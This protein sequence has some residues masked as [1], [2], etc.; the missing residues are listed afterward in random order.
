MPD[1]F[2]VLAPPAA[3]V[4]PSQSTSLVVELTAADEGNYAGLVSFTDN[5]PANGAFA[6]WI[7]G[8]VGPS[9]PVAAAGDAQGDSLPN[10]EGT[11]AFGNTAIGS[12]VC[13][14]ITVANRGTAPLT[15]DPASL[16]VPAGFTV[17]SPPA[18]NV[19]PGGTTSLTLHFDAATAGSFT[20]MVSLTD[21]A[22]DSRSRWWSRA[23]RQSR[24]RPFPCWTGRR[25]SP[26]GPVRLPCPLPRWARPSSKP[27]PCESG[28][29]PA[30]AGPQFARVACGFQPGDAAA[31]TVAPGGSTILA[32]QVDAAT[33]GN[34]GGT[35]SFDDNAPG[36]GIFQ[37]HVSGTV[38]PAA[39]GPG[40]GRRRRSDRGPTG[41]IVRHIQPRDRR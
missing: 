2:T 13:E 39:P 12:P 32:V 22:A 25:T 21:N 23:R 18:A 28:D 31:S 27:S 26:A 36:G 30:G 40:R 1:G 19:A 33:V 11:V 5:D 14:T 6:F 3:S 15:I 24:P 8:T 37:F 29:G 17:V 41:V 20:G 4:A 35:V 7:F 34:Y 16:S 9:V 38:A 10:G